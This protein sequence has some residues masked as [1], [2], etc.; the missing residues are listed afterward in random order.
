MACLKSMAV[1]LASGGAEFY[2]KP[3]KTTQLSANNVFPFN[4]TN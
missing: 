4:L 2:A 1:L 3:S